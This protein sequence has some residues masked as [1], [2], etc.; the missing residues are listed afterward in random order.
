[1][2]R[3]GWT[4]VW[5]DEFDGPAGEQLD[6][7]KWKYDVGPNNANKELEYY[8]DRPENSGKDGQGHFIMTARHEDFMNH[9]YTSAKFTS[10]GTFEPQF[11]RLEAR[12]MLP[13]GKGLWPAFWALGTNIGSVGWPACGEI[14][15]METVGDQ[16]TSNHGSL[17]G[18]GYSGNADLTAVY[19][20]P[21]GTS[22]GDDFHVFA[23]EWE[24]DVVRFY[25]DDHLYETRVPSQ[26]PGNW[27]FNQKFFL[28]M[29]IA[30]GGTW[31]GTPDDSIFPS[32]MSVDYVRVYSR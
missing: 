19:N 30:V 2:V 24:Q 17:H 8:S 4:L 29:N 7:S 15:I 22:F 11:G 9:Q 32:S 13:K 25:V 3:P 31:P 27:V 5:N 28:I 16:L 21:A 12:V 18:P 6:T 10:S 1:M 14:D 26:A 23:A 20:L